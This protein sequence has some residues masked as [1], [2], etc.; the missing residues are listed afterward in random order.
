VAG[1]L[2][3][4]SHGLQAGADTTIA[5]WGERGTAHF[6]AVVDDDSTSEA[7]DHVENAGVVGL[8]TTA[9]RTVD[10]VETATV[11]EVAVAAVASAVG[12]TDVL[13]G[14][15]QDDALGTAS[16]RREDTM[17]GPIGAISS[18]RGTS[19]LFGPSRQA[20]PNQPVRRRA[21]EM[22]PQGSVRIET[23]DG[24]LVLA[25][26]TITVSANRFEG[27][28]TDGDI[29]IVQRSSLEDAVKARLAFWGNTRITFQEKATWE[30]AVADA[31][32]AFRR[33]LESSDEAILAKIDNATAAY[34]AGLARG[35]RKVEGVLPKADGFHVKVWT[36]GSYSLKAGIYDSIGKAIVAK[37]H[38]WDYLKTNGIILGQGAKVTTGKGEK[39]KYSARIEVG[40]RP[41]QIIGSGFSKEE[42]HHVYFLIKDVHCHLTEDKYVFADLEIELFAPVLSHVARLF[43]K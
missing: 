36:G 3:P 18:R 13:S 34:I 32:A 23:D 5:G 12:A 29:E 28:I 7:L 2:D 38:I 24:G 39:V 9:T 15:E 1:T 31:A 41:E 8:D 26:R 35:T 25:K 11:A 19:S 30:K 40:G 27:A 20:H 6:E 21:T 43:P 42:A 16:H 17:N 33:A 37:E 4:R 14:S 22:G 10:L